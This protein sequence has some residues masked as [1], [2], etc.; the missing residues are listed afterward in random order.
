MCGRYANGDV[1]KGEWLGDMKNGEGVMTYASN[2]SYEGGWADDLKHGD[3]T[4]RYAD[5]G[6]FVG[7][8]A[9]GERSGT[10]FLQLTRN[11]PKATPL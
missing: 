2:A 9:R 3:G 6:T 5:G 7:T 1:Y 11:L 4:F 10:R 8:Y